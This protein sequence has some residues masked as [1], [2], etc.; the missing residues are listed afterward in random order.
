MRAS[1]LRALPTKRYS[2]SYW[3]TWNAI[4]LR[5]LLLRITSCKNWLLISR[6]VA[7]FSR[8]VLRAS[9]QRRECNLLRFDSKKLSQAVAGSKCDRSGCRFAASYAA[10][11]SFVSQLACSL[12]IEVQALGIDVCAVHPSPVASNFYEKVGFIR[13]FNLFDNFSTG[14]SYNALRA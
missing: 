13:N 14:D 8:R 10:T 6:R 12:H 1:S 4:A 2:P 5:H 3:R 11:K 9:F 7:S